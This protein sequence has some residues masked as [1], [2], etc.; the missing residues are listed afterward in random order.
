MTT[1]FPEPT[2]TKLYEQDYH[3]WLEKMADL[4][5]TGKLDE[6]DLENLAEE[7]EDMGRSER[8]TVESNLEIVLM[9]LLK[10]R[11]QPE[12][13]SSSWRYTLLEHRRRLERAF[14][15]SP[16]LKG[17]FEQR[18][19]K[20]YQAARKLAAVE[21]DKPISQFPNDCP[22]TPEQVLDLDYLPD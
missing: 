22:F 20:S 13:R 11:Y 4:L 3:L 9:H 10:Y 8:R 12:K 19:A 14:E 5:R 15:E 7:I 6:L 2:A 16:S 1:Q 17:Y 18:F 21:T